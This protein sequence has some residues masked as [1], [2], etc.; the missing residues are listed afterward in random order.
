MELVEL[1]PK[2]SLVILD[3]CFLCSSMML[4]A[5]SMRPLDAQNGEAKALC[6]TDLS[7]ILR[8]EPLFVDSA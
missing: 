4:A 5:S 8:C 2:S 7:R 3:L 1:L 6:F